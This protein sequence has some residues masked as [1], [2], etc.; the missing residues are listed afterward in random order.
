MNFAPYHIAVQCVV[1]HKYKQIFHI[2]LGTL[3]TVR[4]QLAVIDFNCHRKREPYVDSNGKT[5]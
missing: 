3:D 4:N 5:M 1:A 2:L